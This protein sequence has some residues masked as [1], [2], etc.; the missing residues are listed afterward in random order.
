MV[1]GEYA[2]YNIKTFKGV[3]LLLYNKKL[4]HLI[5]PAKHFE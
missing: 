1:H 5:E 4:I 2:I 3:I